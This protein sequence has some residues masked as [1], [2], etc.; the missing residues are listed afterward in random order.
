L[1]AG[2]LA[3]TNPH[4]TSRGCVGRAE[5]VELFVG[6]GARRVRSLFAT[7]RKKAPCI[8]FIDEIDAIGKQRSM[9]NGGVAGVANEERE[10]TLNQV[11]DS[12]KPPP[13]INTLVS[14]GCCAS[15][16]PHCGC[17]DTCAP[18]TSIFRPL[19]SM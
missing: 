6:L 5:F 18:S 15:S 8:V 14:C 19:Y 16:A 17:M 11:G 3:P 13:H 12:F 9:G 4:P 7:A 2:Q 1:F 10:Q